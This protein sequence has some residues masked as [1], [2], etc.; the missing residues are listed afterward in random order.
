[1][2]A[3]V[4]VDIGGTHARF[5]LAEVDAGKVIKLGEAVTLKTAEHASF[6]TAWQ[7]FQRINGAPLPP[8]T[9]IAIAGP[10]DA[11]VIKLTNNPWIIRQEW[12][13]D[14]LTTSSNNG[15]LKTNH[16]FLVACFLARSRS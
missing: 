1:M 15:F 12:Q 13:F 2:T 14:R 9:A 10:V 7:E 6:Q 3:I 5:A 8:A 4:A 11:D 16:F